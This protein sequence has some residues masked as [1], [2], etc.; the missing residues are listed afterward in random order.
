MEEKMSK[1][2]LA[3]L[4][5]ITHPLFAQIYKWIDSNQSTHYSDKPHS[6]AKIVK[7]PPIQLYSPSGAA[8]QD[9]NNNSHLNPAYTL[10]EIIQP[11]DGETIRSNDGDLPVLLQLQPM[12]AKGHKIELIFDG[13]VVGNPQ[14]QLVFNLSAIERGTHTLSAQLVNNTKEIVIKSKTIVIYVHRPYRK[15]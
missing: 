15:R 8:A 3:I 1:F 6:G 9:K 12:I 14:K 4:L 10:L 11:V 2:C 13:K 7:L 5:F